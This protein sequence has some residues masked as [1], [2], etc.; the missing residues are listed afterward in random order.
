MNTH[1][2]AQHWFVSL[3][4]KRY[5][6]YTFAAL[7]EAAAKGVITAETNIWRHGWQQWHPARK[8]PGLLSR[9]S[10]APASAEDEFELIGGRLPDVK[11][12][13]ATVPS[14]DEGAS[15]DERRPR[16]RQPLFGREPH[17]DRPQFSNR[18]QPVEEPE[19]VVA[20][21]WEMQ[22]GRPSRDDGGVKG[23]SRL[24]R[25]RRS[26]HENIPN[27]TNF[28]DG[29]DDV[30]KFRPSARPQRSGRDPAGGQFLRLCKRVAF[31]LIAI[32]LV[33]GAGWVLFGGGLFARVEPGSSSAAREPKPLTRAVAA[34]TSAAAPGS[35]SAIDLPAS[36]ANLPGVVALQRNDPASFERFKKRYAAGAAKAPDDEAM[37]IARTALRKSVKGLLAISSGDTLLEITEAYLAYMQGLQSSNPESCVALSDESKGAR[38]TSNLA[39]EFP[40]QFI[41]DMSILERVAGTNPNA[42]IAP[43][44]VDQARPYLETV[45]G[46]LRQLPVKSELLGRDR[47]DPSEFEPYCTLV[48]AFYQIVLDL[49]RDDKINLLRY[50]YALAAN[51]ADSDLAK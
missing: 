40:I 48:I 47:L 50:L 2:A 41:R 15:F 26:G 33:V 39:K 20:G 28:D 16:G 9:R 17:D 37:P 49:P 25:D 12:D 42:T 34:A 24:G 4:G 5:G 1:S 22:D 18:P 27:S 32:L 30:A 3:N 31:S 23:S 10:P 13:I 44:T 19:E 8:V 6:P 45:F 29:T 51:Q 35:A 46:K 11:A 36:I 38:L 14:R 21:G 43:L 7:T